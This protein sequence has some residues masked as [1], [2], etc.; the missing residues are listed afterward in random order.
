VKKNESAIADPSTMM[1]T[2]FNE[3]KEQLKGEL[4]EEFKDST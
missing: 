4:K 2:M 3:I 1:I